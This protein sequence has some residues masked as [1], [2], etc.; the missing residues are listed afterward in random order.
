M[1]MRALTLMKPKTLVI[2]NLPLRTGLLDVGILLRAVDV[3]AR[4]TEGTGVRIDTGVV[5]GGV[6]CC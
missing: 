6:S 3:V 2:L 4:Q 5:T 1:T